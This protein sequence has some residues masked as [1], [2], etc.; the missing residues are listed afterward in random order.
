MSRLSWLFVIARNSSFS[1]KG[2]SPDVRTVAKELGG[3]YVVEGSVRKAGERVR[4][5]AQL[6]DAETG[7][8]LWAERFDARLDDVFD[9]RDEITTKI[10]GALGPEITKAELDRHSACSP[11]SFDTW[12]MHLKAL[13]YY[14]AVTKAGFEQG[15]QLLNQGIQR[16]SKYSNAFAL[17][18]LLF[19]NAAFHRWA[20]RASL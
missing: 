20:G 1:Y 5:T 8:H 11:A 17:M 9:L 19:S 10:V 12:D 2:A 6:I 14:H 3:R 15:T 13:S 18:S 4:V 16:D 7:N